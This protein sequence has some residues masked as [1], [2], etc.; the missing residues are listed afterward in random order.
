VH[1]REAHSFISRRAEGVAL[2]FDEGIWC[3]VRISSHL[4]WAEGRDER[5]TFF[6]KKAAQ[7]MKP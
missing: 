5:Q 1:I 7:S 6:R 2:A 3:R 4:N